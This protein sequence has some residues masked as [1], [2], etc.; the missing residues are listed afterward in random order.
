[1][2]DHLLP[3]SAD[4]A[5]IGA[6]VWGLA[7]ALAARRERRRRSRSWTTAASRRRPSRRPAC[8][9]PGRSTRTTANATSTRPCGRPPPPGRPSRREVEAA[10]GLASGFHRCGSVYVAARPEH[11]GAVR[12]V[13]DT[14]ARNGRPE[15]WQDADELARASSPGSA[16]PSAAASRSTTSTRPTRPCS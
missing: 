15:D 7:A 4:A 16:R 2:A 9:A 1:M 10:A 5:V 6:G 14:L 12:R 8:S 11:L 3:T 13:R